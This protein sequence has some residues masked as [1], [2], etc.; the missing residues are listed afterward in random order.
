[1]NLPV[2]EIYI[3][4]S[5]TADGDTTHA[6]V[7][8]Q[9]RIRTILQFVG[10]GDHNEQE[11][12]ESFALGKLE[13]TS[14]WKDKTFD[15]LTEAQKKQ[16]YGA[17]V[18]VR[19]LK[20]P[21]E[22]EVRD[23]FR[24]LN[25]YLTKLNDQELRNSTYSGPF[26]KLV[27]ELADDPYW[28]ESKIVST[29]NIRRMKDVQFVSELLIG[30][31]YGPQG[32][33]QREIDT[34]YA[35]FEEFEDEFEGQDKAVA[36]YEK[37]L[38]T[39]KSILPDIQDYRWHYQADFYSLFVALSQLLA[40]K[41]IRK[42]R[43]AVKKLLTQFGELVNRRLADDTAAVAN[44]VVKYVRTVEKS[45][46]DKVRRTTRHKVLVSLLQGYFAK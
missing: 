37:T 38:A 27:N 2:P 45:V 28:T 20:N 5:T 26:V 24:R 42:P 10:V 19:V 36:L 8:G 29:A 35:F 40:E 1:M 25:A 33:A 23:M 39:I 46:T 7:D 12:F 13:A 3:V 41:E 32:G 16:F 18:A 22:I 17:S 4:E 43:K 11:E 6:V 14:P 15:Q 21:S 34:H 30:V 9:Q 44:N 31:I